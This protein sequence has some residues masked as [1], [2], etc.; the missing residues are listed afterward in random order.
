MQY[1]Y[2]KYTKKTNSYFLL[3]F[4]FR[5]LK[6]YE[7][8]ELTMQ[9]FNEPDGGFS[10]ERRGSNLSLAIGD[11][12]QD[13]TYATIQHPLPVSRHHSST[14]DYTTLSRNCNVSTN[15]INTINDIS[16]IC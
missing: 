2:R 16:Y 13:N 5:K 15:Y 6:L 14:P 7:E 12:S 1:L 10:T 4:K 11:T 9:V 3:Y 8:Q